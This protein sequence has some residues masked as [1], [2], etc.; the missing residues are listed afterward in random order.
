VLCSGYPSSRP[1]YVLRLILRRLTGARESR[2][3]FEELYAMQK[4]V[5]PRLY[6]Y[7]MVHHC[8][9]TVETFVRRSAKLEV[10]PIRLIAVSQSVEAVN[11]TYINLDFGMVFVL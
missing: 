11:I 9:F 3:S 2:A 10:P 7:I 4:R 8:A 1:E 6:V 5:Y